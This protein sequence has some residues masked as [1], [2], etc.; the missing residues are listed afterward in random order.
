MKYI[1]CFVLAIA[2]FIAIPAWSKGSIINLKGMT[3]KLAV[4]DTGTTKI[5]HQLSPTMGALFWESPFIINVY[6]FGEEDAIKHL[7]NELFF[8]QP[9]GSL[10]ATCSYTKMVNYFTPE[11][12]GKIVGMLYKLMQ[13][14]KSEHEQLEASNFTKK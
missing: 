9:D 5:S 14:L 13:A 12:I 4:L 11:L 7:I 1:K 3:Q 8:V 6:Q 10:S 2:L